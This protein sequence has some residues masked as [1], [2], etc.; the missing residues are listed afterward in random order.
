MKLFHH[1]DADGYGA[2]SIII[3]NY[4]SLQKEHI[5]CINYEPDVEEKFNKVERGED[6]FIVDYSFTEDTKYILEKLIEKQCKIIWI[7]HHESSINLENS[8]PKFKIIRGI[9]DKSHSGAVL[10][11]MYINN[12]NYDD[13]PFYIK[14]ISDY[15]TFQGKLK[16][17]SDYFKLGY[18][19]IQDKFHLLSKLYKERFFNHITDDLIE[20]GE[21]IKKYIDNDHKL[22]CNKYGFETIIDGI[23]T[24]VINRKCNSW[25]FGDKYYE[26]PMVCS[27]AFNG[28]VYDYS[29]FSSNP[30][31]DCSKVAE[32]FKGGG[33]R[34]AAG[35]LSKDKIF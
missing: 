10:T 19:M 14:L 18:D 23:K 16:P 13:C 4:P 27:Y 20:K 5:Y 33:H 2:G 34:G 35:F 26:Y 30:N 6:I 12:C 31:I 25:I 3:E 17:E 29:L 8:H 7:D 15:D 32:K 28:K 1:N 21:L 24:F 22:Y 9:R 11:Y